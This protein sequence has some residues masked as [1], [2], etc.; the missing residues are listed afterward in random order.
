MQYCTWLK[1]MSY[2]FIDLIIPRGTIQ[3]C[4]KQNCASSLSEPD[5]LGCSCPNLSMENSNASMSF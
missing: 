3:V 1:S 4:R 2:D 5:Y